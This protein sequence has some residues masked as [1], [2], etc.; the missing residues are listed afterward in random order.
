MLQRVWD[1]IRFQVSKLVSRSKLEREMSEELRLHLER[2]AAAQA[3]N[4]MAPEEAKWSAA[5]AFGNV[6]ALQEECRNVRQFAILENFQRD[7][8]YGLRALRRAPTFTAVAV[9]SLALGIGANTAI[10]T[11]VHAFL[12]TSLPVPHPERLALLRIDRPTALLHGLFAKE[13]YSFSYQ[14]FD[15]LRHH[16]SV[17]AGLLVTAAHDFQQQTQGGS[18]LTPGVFVSGD[19]FRTL[20]V[21]PQAGRLL[22]PADD[23]RGGGAAGLV[24]VISDGFWTR[25]FGRDPH[26]LGRTLLLDEQA[27]TIVGVLPPSFHGVFVGGHP[28]VFVPLEYEPTLNAPFSSVTCNSCTWL[29]VMA[30]MKQGS[31]LSRLNATLSAISKDAFANAPVD[32]LWGETRDTVLKNKLVATSGSTGYTYLRQRFTNPLR[33]LMSLALLVLSTACVN[34]ASLL[35]ARSAAREKEFSMRGALGASRARLITQIL[36]E[37]LLVCSAGTLAGIPLAYALSKYLAVS[38]LSSEEPLVL[39]PSPSVIFFMTAITLLSCVAVGLAPALRLTRRPSF[40]MAGTRML[41]SERGRRVL[42]RVLLVA[43]VSLSLL[44]VTGAVLFSGTLFQL[45]EIPLGFNPHRL[46]AIKSSWSK[47]KKSSDEKRALLQRALQRVRSVSGVRSAALAE[48]A[49]LGGSALSNDVGMPGSLQKWDFWNNPVS[50]GYL[51]T[52]QTKLLEGRD[53]RD[54]PEDRSSAVI[55]SR[56]AAGKLFPH[57]NAIGASILYGG[58]KGSLKRVIGVV[59]ENKYVNIR[60]SQPTIFTPAEDWSTTFLIRYSGNAATITK[61][62]SEEL[63][64]IAP[65]IPLETPLSMDQLVDQ[66]LATERLL[67][68]L[69]NFFGAL[70]LLLMAIGLYGTLAYLTARRTPEIGVR[71]AL[72]ATQRAVVWTVTRENVVVVSLGIV[73]GLCAVAFSTR[74]VQSFLYGMQPH[75]PLFLLSAIGLIGLV[76]A[77][78]TGLPALRAARIDPMQALRAE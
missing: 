39:S 36:T 19:Y 10:F 24:A 47:N 5:R 3:E 52:M 17:F 45:R 11:V 51:H 75:D 30:R 43:Q 42:P 54:S 6:G 63:R 35:L 21:K 13:E 38:L 4:G 64:K 41:F 70:A 55:L 14:L 50:P 72:G 18:R 15:N 56:V 77:I 9:L 44:L 20:Q 59:E 2:E 29:T 25:A 71:L 7:L 57:T 66:T 61:Q 53:F 49:P 37:T 67:A 32:S 16:S 31:N 78:A 22:E 74:Y 58:T 28:E 26:A 46:M 62:V 60:D 1:R 34:L 33:L 23:R 69:G 40:L 48:I 8:R 76:A 73:L 65:D 12:L 27:A 68:T